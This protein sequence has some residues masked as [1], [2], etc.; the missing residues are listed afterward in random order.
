MVIF[1]LNH[2]S[3]VCCFTALDFP[4]HLLGV[5]SADLEKKLLS[6][7]MDSKWGGKT[8]NIEVTHNVEQAQ[9]TRDALAK[10]LYS[11]LFDFLVL[12]SVVIFLLFKNVVLFS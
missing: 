10:S 2:V 7:T 12:V 8:E 6:R 3:C 5:N 1:S 11:R 4:R 9:Y